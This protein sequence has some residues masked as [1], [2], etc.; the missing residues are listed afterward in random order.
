MTSEQPNIL[1]LQGPLGPFFADFSVA[2]QG[3][4]A[5][6]HRICF[7]RG[8]HHFADADHVVSFD[9]PLA[10][11]QNWLEAYLAENHIDGVCCYGDCRSY[12]RQAQEVCEQVGV[13]F[14]ALEEGYVRPG[15]VTI[16]QGG[17]NAN[18]PFPANFKADN[19]N[20]SVMPEAASIPDHFRFQFWFAFLYY[21][22]KDWK[23]GGYSHYVHHRKGN[24]ILEMLAWLRGFFRKQLITGWRE[25]GLAKRL[26]SA[27]DGKLFVVPLQVAADM[28]IIC[29]SN[30]DD[31]RQFIEETIQSFAD[32]APKD[33]HLLIKH[34]P[35]D[36]GFQHYGTYVGQLSQARE[37]RN[38]VTYAFDLDLEQVFAH[39]A[40]CVT[41]NSTVGLQALEQGVPTIMLGQSMA[42]TAGLTANDDL[43]E[44][45][46]KPESVNKP[47][48]SAFKKKLVSATQVPGSF[49][50]DRR[51]AAEG[52]A[53]K[54]LQGTD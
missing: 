54:V 29:H 19:I 34:H 27:H 3:R 48:V 14:W 11:W 23:L 40:G 9:A 32:H 33:A 4:G 20:C 45:W 15:F 53:R 47:A 25:A 44:F 39:A 36:R 12:H 2:L 38:R 50:R 30:Y 37:C 46:K 26:V 22:V 28:Q 52:C 8:D 43:G 18:S 31:V 42:R 1:L 49:Y 16:E 24:S 21:A 6:T 5:I 13:K 41:V 35:M 51:E 10:Q 17:N 7:N